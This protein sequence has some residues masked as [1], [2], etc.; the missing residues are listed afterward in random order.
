MTR[1]SRIL[2]IALAVAIGTGSGGCSSLGPAFGVL[3]GSVATQAPATTA[4]AEKALTVTHL[5]LN[6]VAENILTATKNG[7]LHG[8][9]ATQVK[10]WYDAA[11]DG[12]KAADQLDVIANAPGVMAKVDSVTTLIT[13]IQSI[14]G[15]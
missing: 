4:D 14:V 9:L 1:H 5:A 12:L 10:G 11:D 3:T 13:Q 6:T 8:T 7:T 15:K 2:A